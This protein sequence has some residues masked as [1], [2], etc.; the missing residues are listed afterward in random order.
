MSFSLISFF[1]HRVRFTLSFS[2]QFS[3][4]LGQIKIEFLLLENY[5]SQ[6]LFLDLKKISQKAS[7][8]T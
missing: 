2:V 8:S 5:Y 6:T 3:N 1:N 7:S 4:E